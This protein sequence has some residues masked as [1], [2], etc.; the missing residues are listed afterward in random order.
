MFR[1]MSKY[2]AGNIYRGLTNDE[3]HVI[4]TVSK[5][6]GPVELHGDAAGPEKTFIP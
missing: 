4:T 5:H 3:S 6:R 2:R 1:Y